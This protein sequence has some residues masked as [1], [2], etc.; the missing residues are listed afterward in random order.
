MRHLNSPDVLKPIVSWILIP[1]TFK[2]YPKIAFCRLQTHRREAEH[3]AK[4]FHDPF[5]FHN[6]KFGQ[7]LL[8]DHAMQQR[9]N[10]FHTTPTNR[11]TICF[12][13]KEFNN[14]LERLTHGITRWP[15]FNLRPTNSLATPPPKNA[16][17]KSKHYEQIKKKGG[18]KGCCDTWGTFQC[19]QNLEGKY[20][21]IE[22]LIRVFWEKAVA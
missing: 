18:K 9:V 10:K 12:A 11:N 3:R 6:R 22:F 14:I 7:M 4:F 19:P 20:I 17:K 16:S 13:R 1:S 5:L 21:Q 2:I 8:L 15:A